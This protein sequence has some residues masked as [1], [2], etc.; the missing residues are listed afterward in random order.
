MGAVRECGADG[1]NQ[2][3]RGLWGGAGARGAQ[4]MPRFVDTEKSLDFV[5]KVTG[6][7]CPKRGVT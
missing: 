1:T 5:A 4:V 3:W 2:A 6:S 7:S